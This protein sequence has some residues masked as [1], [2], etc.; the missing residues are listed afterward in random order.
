[1]WPILMSCRSTKKWAWS[2][3]LLVAVQVSAYQWR[4]TLSWLS[5]AEVVHTYSALL[6]WLWTSEC[7]RTEA[8]KDMP[9]SHPHFT[10]LRRL[11]L[12]LSYPS[13]L[14]RSPNQSPNQSSIFQMIDQSIHQFPFSYLSTSNLLEA[15]ILSKL[16]TT[17]ILD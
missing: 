7:Q 17:D 1:M 11:D 15:F 9:G 12:R 10:P 2:C 3:T 16:C 4:K 5:R 8:S 14:K 13:I 6:V